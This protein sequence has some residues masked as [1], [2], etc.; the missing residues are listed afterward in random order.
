MSSKMEFEQKTK[1]YK[2]IAN[3]FEKR[4][5]LIV[6]QLMTERN[7]AKTELA[8]LRT[9]HAELE[10]KYSKA[11]TN[12]KVMREQ[13]RGA[14]NVSKQTEKF[15]KGMMGIAQKLVPGLND[16]KLLPDEKDLETHTLFITQ[17]ASFSPK[18]NAPKIVS[19]NNVVNNDGVNG[20]KGASSLVNAPEDMDVAEEVIIQSD[21]DEM[22]DPAEEQ[23]TEAEAGFSS[24]VAAV[25]D[26]DA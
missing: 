15:A 6:E 10:K 26:L 5:K 19:E 14:Q 22:A 7:E 1:G 21:N 24:A 13:L 2:I 8:D 16:E 25:I 12:I 9:K 20:D 3:Q 4:I 18:S 11:D 17:T 23:R